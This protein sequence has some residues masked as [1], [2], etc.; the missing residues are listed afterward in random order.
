MKFS[1][2]TLLWVGIIG[3]SLSMNGVLALA[4]IEETEAESP[5]AGPTD[6]SSELYSILYEMVE[7][8]YKTSDK[9]ITVTV[10]TLRDLP[11]I[12]THIQEKLQHISGP[13]S[14][15]IKFKDELK[16][17]DA[18]T[19]V[20]SILEKISKL[21][22]SKNLTVLVIKDGRLESLPKILGTFHNLKYLFLTGN[23]LG[24]KDA[25]APLE[26]LTDLRHLVLNNNEL[27][28][29][30]Q[31]VTE[32]TKL[33][34]LYLDHNKITKVPSAISNLTQLYTL[35][36]A[37]NKISKLPD[38]ISKLTH[39][40]EL[41]L[42]LNQLGSL[43]D[44][45]ETLKSLDIID[46][47]GNPALDQTTLPHSLANL[48]G[49]RIILV[50]PKALKENEALERITEYMKAILLSV[51]GQNPKL[52]ELLESLLERHTK[53]IL[54]Q[55]YA[56]DRPLTNITAYIV[57]EGVVGRILSNTPQPDQEAEEAQQK[58]A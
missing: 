31:F 5:D 15:T 35:S 42:R 10:G 57:A 49:V 14:L 54:A 52:P 37:G 47:S 43:P 24:G 9:D 11:S 4:A 32:L 2:F 45:F 39:L 23:K 7:E 21:E 19:A 36:L 50:E 38:T 12:N 33:K 29:F 48:Q 28:Q 58:Q 27:T 13:Y 1:I 51:F 16:P 3:F 46:L 56:H 41:D 18:R 44:V 22:P 40:V 53:P 55:R 6:D 17:K 25:L 20:K 34:V 8:K 30:P 26:K